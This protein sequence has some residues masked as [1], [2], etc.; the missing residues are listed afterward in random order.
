MSGI[1][2]FDSTARRLTPVVH[3]SLIGAEWRDMVLA[4]GR[5]FVV[6]TWSSDEQSDDT[7]SV[8]LASY[9]TR[10]SRWTLY[11]A[12][13]LPMRGAAID[14]I[15]TDGCSVFVASADGLAALDAA[16]GVWRARFYVDSTYRLP[17]GA[18]TLVTA[19]STRR[20]PGAKMIDAN[21]Y[22]AMAAADSA[23]AVEEFVRKLAPRHRSDLRNALRRLVSIDTIKTILDLD[24]YD[25][26]GHDRTVDDFERGAELASIA[27]G[28]REFVPFLREAMWHTETQNV[29]A[30]AL[31]R[32]DDR[33]LVSAWRATLDSGTATAGFYAADSLMG[34]GDPTAARWL[35]A[36]APRAR[37]PTQIDGPFVG[38]GMRPTP[39]MALAIL[40]QHGDTA[41]IGI[42]F[43]ALPMPDSA[44]DH[45][46]QDDVLWAMMWLHT[47]TARRM[48]ARGVEE[49]PWLWDDYLAHFHAPIPYQTDTLLTQ[50]PEVRAIVARIEARRATPTRP[51]GRTRSSRASSSPLDDRR[52]A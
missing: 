3:S 28:R 37:T 25:D 26:R 17:D 51:P 5:V 46:R 35:R 49:R 2:V 23:F 19:L 13:E 6:P 38:A 15:A 39:T 8:R 21:D 16:T 18:D 24:A 31:R 22:D 11:R 14:A 36:R 34:R 42:G 1:L 40:A 20:P 44:I 10:T 41:S 27:L 7:T 50:D 9:N 32:I 45:T 29:A 33:E 47:P 43:A 4:G 52:G 48:V 30:D 12:A